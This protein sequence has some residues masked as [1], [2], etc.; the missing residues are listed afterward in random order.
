MHCGIVGK[1]LAECNNQYGANERAKSL[2]LTTN[3][4]DCQHI[5]RPLKTKHSIGF[6]D[7]Q[8]QCL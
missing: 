2:T 1:R 7:T 6:D 8:F 4:H 5:Y 3:D